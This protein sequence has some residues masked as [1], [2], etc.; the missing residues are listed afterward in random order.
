MVIHSKFIWLHLGKAAGTSVRYALKNTFPEAYVATDNKPLK[1]ANHEIA[2]KY[3]LN[4]PEHL[5]FCICFRKL[6]SW[7]VS[8]L[9][10]Q[11][12][13]EIPKRIWNKTLNGDL[14]L[15]ENS[16]ARKEG[17]FEGINTI[18]DLLKYYIGCKT[19]YFIRSEF[20]LYDFV[21]FFK[22][23]GIEGSRINQFTN[24]LSNLKLNQRVG[25]GLELQCNELA[26]LKA[27]CPYWFSIQQSIY[28]K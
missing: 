27:S 28:T 13:D 5:P 10:Q 3:N 26:I 12:G 9:M 16:L 20:L 19:P 25:G 23:I 21:N 4:V 22:S 11:Y 18:D 7:V 6:E 1:H 8:H 24:H 15:S 2:K 17:V 14:C